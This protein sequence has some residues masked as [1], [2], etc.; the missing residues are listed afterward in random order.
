MWRLEN[1]PLSVWSNDI[2]VGLTGAFLCSRSFGMAM[3]SSDGG[4]I[5]NIAS[6]LALI[7]PDQRIYRLLL[8]ERAALSSS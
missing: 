5:V 6:D 8:P 3:A 1:L 2:A 4:V 7:G